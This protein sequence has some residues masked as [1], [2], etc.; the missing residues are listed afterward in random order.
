MK[1]EAMNKKQALIVLIE[2]SLA[3]PDKT[4]E[5]ILDK[6]DNFSDQEIET[7]GRFLALEKKQSLQQGQALLPLLEKEE[8]E[9]S[10]LLEGIEKDIKNLNLNLD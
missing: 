1:E 6:I 5:K 4:K 3:I 9:V 2:H 10:A 7:L 8:K